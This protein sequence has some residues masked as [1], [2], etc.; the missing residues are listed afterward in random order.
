MRRMLSC[1]R[2]DGGQRRRRSGSCWWL[3]PDGELDALVEGEIA[4]A[5]QCAPGALARGE[6]R[7]AKNARA[8]RTRIS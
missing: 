7:Y 4:S 8:R 1:A 6:R 3:R 5:L 2:V